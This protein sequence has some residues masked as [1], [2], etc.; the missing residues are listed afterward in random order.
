M[1]R[2]YTKYALMIFFLL[3]AVILSACEKPNTKSVKNNSIHSQDTRDAYGGVYYRIQADY[4]LIETGEPLNFDFIIS[5]YNREVPGS[6][7][8]I[9][10]PRTMFK[11]TSTGA[12]IAISPPK[13]YCQR[14]LTGFSLEKKTDL[15]KKPLLAWYPD[16]TNLSYAFVYLTNDA[17][18]GPQAK[19]R[20]KGYKFTRTDKAA[21]MAWMASHWL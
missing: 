6:F 10:K 2:L 5:C 7:N 9:L 17:Y 20:F 13:H 3:F 12:A 4:E 15:L 18:T 21:F 11:A 19:I 14:A 1:I 16:V 8:G